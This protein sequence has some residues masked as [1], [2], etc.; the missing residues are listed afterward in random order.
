M[1]ENKYLLDTNICIHPPHY[2]A[3]PSAHSRRAADRFLVK[4]LPSPFAP[5]EKSPNFAAMNIGHIIIWKE[6][7]E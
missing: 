4:K 1:K 2:S 3:C 6:F 7:F 5:S